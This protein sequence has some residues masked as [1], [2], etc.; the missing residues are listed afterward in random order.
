MKNKA[1]QVDFLTK[2]SVC[3]SLLDPERVILLDEKEQK[4]TMHVSCSKCNSAVLVFLSN[5]S[6]GTLSI[7]IATDLDSSEARDKFGNTAISADEVIDLYQFITEKKG[8]I[9][10]LLK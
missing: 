8:D 1:K 7:G 5:N 6:A 10:Q 9:R 4:T 3:E 2:C